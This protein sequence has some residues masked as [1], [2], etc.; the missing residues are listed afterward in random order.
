MSVVVS[1]DRRY[2]RTHEAIIHHAMELALVSG[3]KKVSVTKLTEKA[4]INRN[5]FYLHFNTIEDVF[6][7]IEERFLA[8]YRDFVSASPLLDVL[9]TDT[10]Y[11]VAF[12]AFLKS[13]ESNVAAIAKMGRAEQLVSKIERIWLDYF[14]REL[15]S[16][17]KY[18][19]AKDVILPYIAGCTLIF[20]TNWVNDPIG[21]DIQK[22]TWF[23]GKFIE[24]TLALEA[25]NG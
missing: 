21:F 7:E 25:E 23:N 17:R 10:D 24:R 20:F 8:K 15:S 3:W 13:E 6:D 11:Y 22:N 9:V 18:S 14:D 2:Q 12:S 19:R 4:N 1:N 5:S 16:S